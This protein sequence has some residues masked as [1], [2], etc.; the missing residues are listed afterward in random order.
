MSSCANPPDLNETALIDTAT[1][2]TLLTTMSPATATNNADIQITVIQPGGNC[3]TT[4][5]AI[6]LILQNLP[7]EV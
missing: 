7:P 3:M 5:H 1:S 4:T 6:N 2:C